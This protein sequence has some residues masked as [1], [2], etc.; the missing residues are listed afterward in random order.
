M[1]LVG[2]NR[3]FIKDFNKVSSP[4]F[5]LLAKDIEFFL[6]DSHQ[7]SLEILKEKLTIT[8]ILRGPNWALP[9]HIHAYAYEKAIRATLGQIDDK[10]PYAIYF[11]RKKL[12]KA[13]LNYIV[14][15]KELLA[16]FHSLNKFRHYI[17]DY[18]TFVHIYH[19]AIKYLMKNLDVN[20][21]IIRWFLLL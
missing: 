2:Y 11:I 13:E 3:R 10:Y 4:L 17:T 18:Q 6:S 7:E 21:R 8:P 16:V 9:F 5:G 14:T 15:Q 1:G 12:S 19:D 20:T